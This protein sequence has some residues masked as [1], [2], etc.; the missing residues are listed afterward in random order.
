VLFLFTCRKR[1]E[2]NLGVNRILISWHFN[3]PLCLALQWQWQKICIGSSVQR[4]FTPASCRTLWKCVS[5]GKLCHFLHRDL[6]TRYVHTYNAG[7]SPWWY[8]W[9]FDAWSLWNTI[10]ICWKWSQHMEGRN[11]L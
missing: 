10:C 6:P 8:F 3:L 5:M 2:N 4:L 9:R 11:V 1:Q 7:C